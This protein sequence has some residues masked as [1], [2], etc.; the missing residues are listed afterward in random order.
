MSLEE[1]ALVASVVFTGLFSGLYAM[2]NLILHK[3]MGGMD[4]PEFARFLRSFLPVARKSPFNYVVVIGMVVA[5]AVA[6]I[7]M[8]DAG[9]TAFVLTAIGLV[10][11]LGG[12]AVVSNRIAEPNYDR[13]LAWDPDHM[14]GSWEAVR[15]YYFKLNWIR[16]FS[17]WTAFGLF[18][19]ALV[20]L[21]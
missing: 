19:A 14:P 13:M 6:L 10:F 1:W 8:D 16:A 18:I 5:P 3:V 12:N 21:L 2:L 15:R 4:G 17:T 9:S 7:A 11:T 20:D